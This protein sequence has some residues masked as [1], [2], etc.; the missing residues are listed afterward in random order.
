MSSVFNADN[1]IVRNS[2][3]LQR[4][5]LIGAGLGGAGL[6]LM[7]AWGSDLALDRF[8][9][10]EN[11]AHLAGAAQRAQLLVDQLLADRERQAEVLALT[12]SVVGAAREGGARAAT[13][14]ITSTSA[15]DL[16]QRFDLER[17][18]QASPDARAFLVGVLP[19]L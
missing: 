1:S 5:F 9:R 19:R 17:S 3:S 13:L 6:I 18:L 12:S 8:A 2:S 15:P 11:E 10:R 4:R 7:L 16:E 14:S